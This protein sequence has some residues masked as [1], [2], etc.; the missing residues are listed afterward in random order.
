MRYYLK[1]SIITPSYNQVSF[2]EQTILSVLGQ[3]YPNLEYII[4]D[5]GST[6]GSVEI[7]KKYENRLSYWVSEKDGGQAPAI[8]NGFSHATGD[9]LGWLNS[10]YLFMPD[11]LFYVADVMQSGEQGIYF[12]NCI[13]YKEGNKLVTWGSDVKGDSQKFSLKNTDFIIQPSSFWSRDVWEKNGELNENLNY[14]FDWEWYL[15]AEANGILFFPVA[16]TLALYRIHDA[17]KT[18]TGGEK[19]EDEI[20]CIYRKY[21]PENVFL[22]QQLRHDRKFTQLIVLRLFSKILQLFCLK[23]GSTWLLKMLKFKKYRSF[24]ISHINQVRSMLSF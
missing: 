2:L 24:S 17:H 4:M 23:S 5:G 8:N 7:I 11:T 15:R 9:I 18:G 14:A 3:N 22:F 10:D 16:K 12:G 13:R 21:L 20:S 1:I 19:R 6:D